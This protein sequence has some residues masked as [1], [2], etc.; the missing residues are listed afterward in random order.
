MTAD[1]YACGVLLN[2][3][4]TEELPYKKQAD[5]TYR[6]IVAK[7]TSSSPEDRYQSAQ[8][9]MKA[10]NRLSV[11]TH[12]NFPNISHPLRKIVFIVY[13]LLIHCISIVSAFLRKIRILLLEYSGE[14]FLS[15]Y[16]GLSFLLF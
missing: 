4:L 3:L 5:G 7:A 15:H 11:P 8:E 6:K 14:L 9:M 2:V 13:S 1:I 16:I 10:L 12:L